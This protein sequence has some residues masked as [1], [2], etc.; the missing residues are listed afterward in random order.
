MIFSRVEYLRCEWYMGKKMENC[1]DSQIEENLTDALLASPSTGNPSKVDVPLSQTF[2][3]TLSPD[4]DITQKTRKQI[5]SWC[6]RQLF[7]FAVLEISENG[8]LHAHIAVCTPEKR[9]PMSIHD[10]WWKK[11]QADRQDYP[12]A[13]G[14]RAVKVNVM[15]N[16]KWYDEYLRKGGE[17]I[18][19]NYKRDTDD[20]FPT[21]DEQA[22]LVAK[23]GKCN[24]RIHYVFGMVDE[25]KTKYPEDGSMESAV[26]FLKFR[27]IELRKE[28]IIMDLRKRMQ[29]CHFMYEVRNR[30]IDPCNEEKQIID[31]IF[32]YDYV[33]K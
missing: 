27:M 32:G 30:I 28:P 33:F 29:L 6:K 5:I 2:R 4:R 11:L 1:N 3:V 26:R 19:D 24:V 31:K 8:K 20:Y 25:W 23:I 15:F 16:H 9:E 10:Q 18:F 7:A 17:V 22:Q 14:K 21:T 12:N 13:I